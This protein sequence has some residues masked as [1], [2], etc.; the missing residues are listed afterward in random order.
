MNNENSGIS[1]TSICFAQSIGLSC[2]LF[3]RSLERSK[4][5]KMGL[6]CINGHAYLRKKINRKKAVKKNNISLCKFGGA[7]LIYN[8]YSELG[9]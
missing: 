9:E 2:I 8:L 7:G 1:F 6:N 3:I 5:P 4:T